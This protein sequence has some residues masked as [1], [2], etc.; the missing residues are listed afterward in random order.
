[1]KIILLVTILLLSGCSRSIDQ[2]TDG[3]KRE[4]LSIEKHSV[5]C[6]SANNEYFKHEGVERVWRRDGGQYEIVTKEALITVNG[7]CVVNEFY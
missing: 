3:F 1:M 4:N 5:V 7:D 2:F 6:Y